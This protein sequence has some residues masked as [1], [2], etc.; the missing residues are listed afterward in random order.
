NRVPIQS[1][2]F[3]SSGRKAL[4]PDEGKTVDWMGTR[5]HSASGPKFCHFIVSCPFIYR[6]SQYLESG[7]VDSPL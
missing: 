2:V 5:F 4:R 6:L 7:S 1:T 3:P